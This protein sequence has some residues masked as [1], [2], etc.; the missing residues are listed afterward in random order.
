LFCDTGDD[1]ADGFIPFLYL[2]FSV[3]GLGTMIIL[4]LLIL[5]TNPTEPY[6]TSLTDT[7]GQAS[8][9]CTDIGY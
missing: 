6:S 3:L 5:A 4:T 9:A 7:V 8:K 1:A 2:V